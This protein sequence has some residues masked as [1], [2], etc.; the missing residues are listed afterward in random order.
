MEDQ[1]FTKEGFFRVFHER[2]LGGNRLG[3]VYELAVGD[4]LVGSLGAWLEGLGEGWSVEAWEHRPLPLFSLKKNRSEVK[5]HEGRLTSWSAEERKKDLIGITTRRS[6]EAAGV[7]RDIRTR[8]IRPEWVG[9]WNPT[10]RPT[11]F[12]RMRSAGYQLVLV[13]QRMEFY[14]DG[15]RES[16]VGSQGQ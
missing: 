13:Y 8:Q 6:R 5:I 1:G 2:F 9:L 12:Q 3:R 16:G 14:V 4:G 15:E 11:W 10:M 7:C